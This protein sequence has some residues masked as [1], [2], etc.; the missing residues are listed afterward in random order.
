MNRALAVFV[1]AIALATAGAV[2]LAVMLGAGSASA[3]P[4]P[5][6]LPPPPAAPPAPAA[7]ATPPVVPPPTTEVQP[8]PAVLGGPGESCRAR[9]DCRPGLLC[10]VQICVD[11]HEG[12][13][14]GATP[15]CGGELKCIGGTCR[16]P[17]TPTVPP[18]AP[19]Y[20]QPYPQSPAPY[21]YPALPGAQ[22]PAADSG[23]GASEWLAFRLKG[24][25]F[26][27][28]MT[29]MGGP[30]L[31]VFTG[32]FAAGVAPVTKDFLWALR[33]GGLFGRHELGLEVSPGTYAWMPDVGL[34][35]QANVTYGYFIPV[36]QSENVGVYWPMRFGAGVFTGHTGGL[37]FVETRADLIG[38]AV[39]VGHVIFD[40][41]LPSYRYAVSPAEQVVH[42]L[43]WNFGGGFAYA[44]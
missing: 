20:P 25:H 33:I 13:S 11:P 16:S 32:S 19:A 39:Q 17:F 26:F 4:G 21:P 38:L 8:P 34:A 15:D 31:P 14:C 23:G 41:H 12:E 3:Q 44:L 36:Y 9:S 42:V 18:T 27:A 40:L 43:S 10:K 24:N 30:V 2:C 29:F 5:R 37:V 6:Q 28:G 1:R 22:P 7:S 35:F